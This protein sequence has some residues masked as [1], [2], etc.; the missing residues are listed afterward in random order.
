[1]ETT[2]VVEDFEYELVRGDGPSEF[3]FTKMRTPSA[4]NSASS[5]STKAP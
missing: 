4:T 3:G 1:M 2:D 5:L